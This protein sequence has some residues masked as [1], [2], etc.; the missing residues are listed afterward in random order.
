MSHSC[1]LGVGALRSTVHAAAQH[2]MRPPCTTTA[3]R[4]LPLS[5]TTTRCFSA[6][7]PSPHPRTHTQR[8][9]H[10]LYSRHA[11]TRPALRT[12]RPSLPQW[13]GLGLRPASTR[14]LPVITR[15]V[16]LPPTYTDADGLPFANRDLDT[17]EAVT[18]FGPY[19]DTLAANQLLRILHGRRVA[20]TL[21]D[22]A[23]HAS[24]TREFSPEHQELALEFLRRTLAVDE[25]VNAGLRAED[26]LAALE[27]DATGE[28]QEDA[29]QQQP[30]GVFEAMRARNKAKWDALVAQREEDAR[31]QAEEAAHGVAGPLQVGGAAPARQLTAKMQE[32]MVRGQSDLEAPPEMSKARRLLPSAG[33]VLALCGLCLAGAEWYKAPQRADRLWPDIPPAAATVGVLIVANVA[34]WA[35]WKV[36]P[37]WGP[38]NRYF[39]L[40]AATPRAAA[41]LASVF[42]HQSLL[43]LA[44][45]MAGLWL[46][47]VRLHDEVGRG[48]FLATYFA[49]GAA[50]SLGTLAAAVLR[51]RLDFTSLGASGAIYGV[52][53]A[54]LW[55]HRLESFKVLGL[56]PPP[57]EGVAGITLLA[58]LAAWNI[59]GFFRMKRFTV[60]FTAHL[61]GLC[62]GVLAGHLIERRRAARG[63]AARRAARGVMA[64]SKA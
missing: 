49:A 20:G 42:S 32:Y 14:P 46:L 38:L 50:G 25:V 29:A 59:G 2:L 53:A 30:T 40:T 12:T 45:N 43:H 33:F 62:T 58:A 9:Q 1:S 44:T 7:A 5:I 63:E 35:L 64:G 8:K 57:S 26:E 34:G 36:P 52:G 13:L 60:D 6:A 16:D 28:N 54:Y 51:G 19:L 15:Y 4:L 3:A 10:L 22:P 56:P 55:L 47:G 31:K 41:I 11:G 21:E 39:I 48:T 17:S 24:L 27:A 18:I 37:L 61:V 23:L